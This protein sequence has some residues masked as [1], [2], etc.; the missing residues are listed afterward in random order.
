MLRVATILLRGVETFQPNLLCLI[1]QLA[2]L[3]QHGEERPREN[4][5]FFCWRHF[6][7][8]AVVLGA[9]TSPWVELMAPIETF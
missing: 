6:Y 9:P 2:S 3:L 8:M 5:G 4:Y 7:I 1:A